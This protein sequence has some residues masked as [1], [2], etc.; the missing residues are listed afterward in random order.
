MKLISISKIIYQNFIYGI[1][2]YDKTNLITV[3]D[4]EHECSKLCW[5]TIWKEL[6]VNILKFAHFYFS[7]GIVP[8]EILVPFL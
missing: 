4:I 2:I 3:E 1:T 8:Y 6:F 5:I 7:T